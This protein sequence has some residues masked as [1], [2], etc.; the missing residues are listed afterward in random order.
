M[1]KF[2]SILDLVSCPFFLT[3][4]NDGP[5]VEPRQPAH[6]GVIIRKIPVPGQG[7]IFFEERSDIVLAMGPVGV[8]RHLTFAPGRQIAV[9]V[10]KQIARLLVK[11]TR[12]LVDVHL[13]VLARLCAQFPRPYPRSR[14]AAFSNSR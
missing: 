7:G 6:D 4:H 2:R 3:D 1:P 8:A 5:V 10:G 9:K 12:L 13:V 11:S 14:Q